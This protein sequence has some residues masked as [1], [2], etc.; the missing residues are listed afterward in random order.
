MDVPHSKETLTVVELPI[1]VRLPLNVAE[2]VV[3]E[4]AAELITEGGTLVGV[5]IIGIV[6]TPPPV[7]GFTEVGAGTDVVKVIS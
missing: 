6:A 2:L 5:Y 7:G 4:P 3:I 1:V